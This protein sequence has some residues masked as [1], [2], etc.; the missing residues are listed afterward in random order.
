MSKRKNHIRFVAVV[1]GLGL[2][3]SSCVTEKNEKTFVKKQMPYSYFPEDTIGELKMSVDAWR[4]LNI[5]W[6]G[7]PLLAEGGQLYSR[8]YIRKHAKLQT[9]LHPYDEDDSAR[10]IPV[11]VI[12]KDSRI[13]YVWSCWDYNNGVR[14]TNRAVLEKNR[15][16]LDTTIQF[17]KNIP[18]YV[19]FHP[20][21]FPGVKTGYKH[22]TSEKRINDEEFNCTDVND[23]KFTVKYLKDKKGLWI[24]NNCRELSLKC[25]KGNISYSF[26][27]TIKSFN[28]NFYTG[29]T[30]AHDLWTATRKAIVGDAAFKL[31]KEIS[32]FSWRT[33]IEAGKDSEV[34]LAPLFNN[35]PERVQCNT[36]FGRDFGYFYPDENVKIKLELDNRWSSKNKKTNVLYELQNY[37]NQ[38]VKQASIKKILHA[39]KENYVEFDFGKLPR[40]AYSGSVLVQDEKGGDIGFVCFR[41][42]VVPRLQPYPPEKSFF[43]A[44]QAYKDNIQTKIT[45]AKY[46]GVRKVRFRSG[47]NEET[48][49]RFEP[50]KGKFNKKLIAPP[51]AKQYAK[52]NIAMWFH[53]EQYPPTLF[54]R[55]NTFKLPAGL[56]KDDLV[57]SYYHSREKK[58]AFLPKEDAPFINYIKK[59]VSNYPMIH[60]YEV[61]NEPHSNMDIDFA[62]RTVRLVSQ[63]V[64]SLYP[65]AKIQGMAICQL[66]PDLIEWTEKVL[67]KAHPYIDTVS[68]HQYQNRNWYKLNSKSYFAPIETLG[69]EKQLAAIA[70]V[71]KKYGKEY[72]NSEMSWVGSQKELL[73][74]RKFSD[75]EKNSVNMFLRSYILT[76][77]GGASSITLCF[78]ISLRPTFCDYIMSVEKAACLVGL[79]KMVKPWSVAHATLVDL[80]DGA[81]F[82]KRIDVKSKEVYNMLFKGRKSLWA[83]VWDYKNP[84]FIEHDFEDG[85]VVFKDAAG[86]VLPIKKVMTISGAPFFIVNK[87]LS[88][89]EFKKR[90]AA[91]KHIPG[92]SA[93]ITHVHLKNGSNKTLV[94]NLENITDKSVKIKAL[95]Y[96]SGYKNTFKGLYDFT[97]PPGTH[98]FDLPVALA[99]T[100]KMRVKMELKGEG[101]AEGFYDSVSEWFS[102]PYIQTAKRFGALPVYQAKTAPHIDGNPSDKAWN[103]ATPIILNKKEQIDFDPKVENPLWKGPEDLS[104]KARLLWDDKY[105]YFLAEVK[106]DV[107]RNN[108]KSENIAAWAGDGIQIAL[109]L[110]NDSKAAYDDDDHEVNIALWNSKPVIWR[111]TFGNE[112]ASSGPL[113]KAKLAIVRDE[114]KKTTIYELALPLEKMPPWKGESLRS[115][116][117]KFNFI[118]N[119]DDGKTVRRTKWI[120]I[121]KGIA[122]TKNPALYKNMLFLNKN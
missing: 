67:K 68:F 5:E 43:G 52:N 89:K 88:E 36:D 24:K 99:S 20:V 116:C 6:N 77:A 100:T 76:K 59:L 15:V 16:V 122:K 75:Q 53:G 101:K 12:R 81:D 91:M 85:K 107:Y 61:M 55:N 21:L 105:L 40:S 45:L 84:S 83:A 22:G 95:G 114:A 70:K 8:K 86:G 82:L 80:M 25:P 93:R 78:G 62:A 103:D 42:G 97:L 111:R 3:L 30:W 48:W 18:A 37:Q 119:D 23:K 17:N 26:S 87:G 44:F 10:D 90:L 94:V 64:K 54:M 98:S 38:I 19:Y 31:N 57:F 71:A 104:V 51:I 118:V 9:G 58:D 92:Q 108:Q 56:K 79:R 96:R 27:S 109:D 49:A 2:L 73:P 4:N 33:V 50:K 13:E 1:M 66:E 121:T 117:I 11:R 60:T 14:Q 7:I 63:G 112:D 39:K 74:K 120:A 110:R 65:K 47:Q 115:K 106:D 46:A 32:E 69:W 28:L 34:K 113:K 102:S 41:F 29:E 35:F 72:C